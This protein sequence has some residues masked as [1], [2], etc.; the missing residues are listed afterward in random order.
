MLA[1]SLAQ[2]FYL[3]VVAKQLC[4]LSLCHCYFQDVKKDAIKILTLQEE[5]VRVRGF[6]KTA[7]DSATR[8]TDIEQ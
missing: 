4:W 7:N 2:E 3:D 8:W 6:D 5:F 1:K